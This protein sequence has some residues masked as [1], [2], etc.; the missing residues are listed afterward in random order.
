MHCARRYGRVVVVGSV[1]SAR[2]CPRTT[3]SLFALFAP[4]NP[5]HTAYPVRS[6]DSGGSSDIDRRH[7]PSCVRASPALAICRR[8]LAVASRVRYRLYRLPRTGNRRLA[9]GGFGGSL[10]ILRRFTISPR[11]V[12]CQVFGGVVASS[13]FGFL[14]FS[15]LACCAEVSN[16][17]IL[18]LIS[19]HRSSI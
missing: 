3:I 10:P 19:N 16:D 6:A 14:F 18:R 17:R 11:R 12:I 4:K 9:T 7:R 1:G 13:D 8:Q 2:L 5:R 15:V